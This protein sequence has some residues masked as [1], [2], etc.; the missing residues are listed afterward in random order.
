MSSTI[1]ERIARVCTVTCALVILGLS[2][3]PT[4]ARSQVTGSEPCA[5]SA[6]TQTPRADTAGR[7]L[8]LLRSGDLLKINVFRNKELTGD[9]LIDSQGR[10]VIPGLGVVRAAGLDPAQVEAALRELLVCQGIVPDVSVQAQIR[11]SI[12][13]EVRNPGVFPVDPGISLLQVLTLAGG[14]TARGDLKHA[15]VVREGKSYVV[16]LEKALAG[17]ASGDIVLNSNDVVVI[18]E[19]GGFTREDASF[20]LG[21]LTAVASVINIILTLSRR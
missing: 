1:P 14:Q 3:I 20:L 18:P 8:G 11:V 12:L 2:L 21:G 13:G 5:I 4:S 7:H 10:L 15:R 16:D 17:D 9:Y 6:R 19:N